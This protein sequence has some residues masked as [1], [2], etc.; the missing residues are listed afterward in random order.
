MNLIQ[1]FD[2]LQR[3]FLPECIE[4]YVDQDNLVRLIDAFVDSL[5]LQAIGF[6]FPKQN[7]QNRGRPGYHPGILLKLYL[8]G[9]F[10]QIRSS[11]RL[12]AECR[13][14]L[15]VIWLL[16]KLAPDFKTIADFRKDNAGAFKAVL[17]Q[18]NQLCQ[19]LE[20]FGGE[21][22]AID[23]SKVKAQNAPDQNWSLTKL[24]KQKEKLDRRMEDYLKALEVEESQEQ[25][26]AARLTVEQLKHKIQLIKEQQQEINHKVRQIETL[27]QT[28]LSATDPESR[29]MK[30]AKGHVV[31]YNVQ[32][33]VDAKHHL[34]ICTQVTNTGVDQGLLAPMIQA[35]KA[36]LP[37]QK[38]DVVADGGYFKAE[39]IKSCQEMGME[40]HLAQVNNSPSERAGLFGKKDFEYDPQKDLYRCP[41]GQ[42]LTKRREMIDKGRRL[43]NYDHP[44]ACAR[45]GLRQRCTEAQ[46]RTLSRW[47]HEACLER[48][49]AQ[50]AAQPE[51]LAKRKALIEH[52]WGT[53]K[54][55]LGGGFLLKGLKKVGAEVSLAHWVYNLKR[56]L[57]V[58]GLRKL[59]EA[60]LQPPDQSGPQ[61][62]EATAGA[63]DQLKKAVGE[64][65]ALLR[66]ENLQARA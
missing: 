9:Y 13:R 49:A 33:V 41:A 54:W 2:R 25:P 32:G 48:M 3:L 57:N 35:A 24:E 46:Y 43:F 52:C 20:L 12:E 27:G 18:F 1:G 21:L 60:L 40:A 36:E 42:H 50:V 8:Y 30:G 19:R 34:L 58:V 38:A 47:E 62:A 37:M 6:L 64:I 7:R 5:D 63:L 44:A 39:D 55:V 66:W 53:L 15:E 65:L 23:G 26:Q 10:H 22:I 45:C 29:S 17:R 61:K 11:R 4:D 14:N 31:G 59:L 56:A 16:G 51:K 28:Q